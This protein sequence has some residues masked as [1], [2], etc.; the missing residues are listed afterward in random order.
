MTQSN[1]DVP[2][3]EDRDGFDYPIY[4]FDKGTL[5]EKV[6]CGTTDRAV[7]RCNDWD[8]TH[9]ED[10]VIAKIKTLYPGIKATDIFLSDED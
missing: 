4:Q 5:Y 7:W 10:A 9:L 1:P 8:E 3:P 2:T 6:I